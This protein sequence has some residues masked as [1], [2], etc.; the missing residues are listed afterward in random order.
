M[1]PTDKQKESYFSQMAMLL[2]DNYKKRVEKF[3]KEYDEKC[4]VRHSF[5]ILSTE[6]F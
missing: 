4:S 2:V 3:S 1:K 6:M 5:W